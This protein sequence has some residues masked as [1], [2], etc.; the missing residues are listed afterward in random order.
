MYSF[1]LQI[2]NRKWDNRALLN[3]YAWRVSSGVTTR[4][5]CFPRYTLSLTS[6]SIPLIVECE[7]LARPFPLVQTTLPQIANNF[8]I[9]K[10]TKIT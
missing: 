7:P 5:V 8:Y 4:K 2:P 9:K 3:T 1:Y 6:S 10:I